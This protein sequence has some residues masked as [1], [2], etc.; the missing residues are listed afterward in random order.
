M[1][2]CWSLSKA[3]DTR[4]WS[5]CHSSL[6]ACCRVRLY[7]LPA[8]LQSSRIASVDAVTQCACLAFGCFLRIV[9][10]VWQSAVSRGFASFWISLSLAS[11]CWSMSSENRFLRARLNCFWVSGSFSLAQLYLHLPLGG[12]LEA[13]SESLNWALTTLWSEP[14]S[15][16]LQARQF[17]IDFHQLGLITM[18]SSCCLSPFELV[19]VLRRDF[20]FSKCERAGLRLAVSHRQWSG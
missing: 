6:C 5:R 8:L 11:G 19:K 17:V 1:W 12:R 7:F 18:W 2:I 15:M 4:L 10:L 14:I 9:S 16:V 20:R 3:F 13:R